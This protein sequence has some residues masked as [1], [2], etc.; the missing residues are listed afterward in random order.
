MRKIADY[1]KIEGDKREEKI[2]RLCHLI[3]SLNEAVGNSS[4]AERGWY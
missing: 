2:Q 1:L 4:Y 3:I